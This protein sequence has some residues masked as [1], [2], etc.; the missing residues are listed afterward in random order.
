M[1]SQLSTAVNQ[2]EF[3]A[4]KETLEDTKEAQSSYKVDRTFACFPS[5][6]YKLSQQNSSRRCFLENQKFWIGWKLVK[7]FNGMV[8]DLVLIYV[9]LFDDSYWERIDNKMPYLLYP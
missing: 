9:L 7:F 8:F 1:K 5:N 3:L 6:H 2:E 4:L